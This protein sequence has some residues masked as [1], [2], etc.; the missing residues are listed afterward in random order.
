MTMTTV[1]VDVD[2]YLDDVLESASAQ[3]IAKHIK[4]HWDAK[5]RDDLISELLNMR[6]PDETD[7]EAIEAVRA[8]F[9]HGDAFEARRLFD[10]TWPE[11]PRDPVAIK[12]A[13]DEW[14]ATRQ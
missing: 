2:V 13:Y 6:E 14:K 5:D 11:C 9:R 1:T 7:K 8:A 4:R 12:K 3:E 10:L